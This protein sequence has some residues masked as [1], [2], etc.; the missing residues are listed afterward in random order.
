MGL[1]PG[2]KIWPSHL[3]KLQK[4]GFVGGFRKCGSEHLAVWG[5]CEIAELGLKSARVLCK[6]SPHKGQ[7]VLHYWGQHRR[8]DWKRTCWKLNSKKSNSCF[9]RFLKLLSFANS[10]FQ[11]HVANFEKACLHFFFEPTPT[12]QEMRKCN[13]RRLLIIVT[14]SPLSLI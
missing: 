9:V 4:R 8:K 12:W 11:I 14:L 7:Q 1:T 10:K 3:P 2:V 6:I 5:A 13:F